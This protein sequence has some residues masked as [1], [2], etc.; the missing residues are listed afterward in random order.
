M[1]YS[2]SSEASTPKSRHIP[3]SYV[4]N[5]IFLSCDFERI[6]AEAA[7]LA[8]YNRKAIIQPRDIQTAVKLI[9]GGKLAIQLFPELQKPC[10][11]MKLQEQINFI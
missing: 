5:G 10:Q 11:N 1:V 8:R 3:K 9:L 7:R 2:Q 4:N 6:A